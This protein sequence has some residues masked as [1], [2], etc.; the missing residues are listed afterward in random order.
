MN[1]KKH[2]AV[3]ACLFALGIALFC[4]SICMASERASAP[5]SHE[6]CKTDAKAPHHE[7]CSTCSLHSELTETRQVSLPQVLFLPVFHTPF[8]VFQPYVLHVTD[9]TWAFYHP[10]DYLNILKTIR[11]QC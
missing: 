9:H 2:L 1:M 8:L 10:P 11:M 4:P 7:S 3:L 5:A 6:C